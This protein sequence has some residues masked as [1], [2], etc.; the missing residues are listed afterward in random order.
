MR[1]MHVI[2]SLERGGAQAVL[3]DLVVQFQKQGC[4]QTIVYMHDGPYRERFEA[5]GIQTHQ[6]T[7]I[8]SLFD[9]IAL[10]RLMALIKKV[11]PDYLH[12]LLWA[13]NWLGR[14]AARLLRIP[15]V[16]SLH[17]NYDQ[18]G[19]VR[20]VLDR[21]MPYRVHAIIAVSHEV[22]QSFCA[23]YSNA[24]VVVIPN[25]ID[26][27]AVFAAAKI[28][29]KSRAQLD[30]MDTD[31]VIGSV[32]RFHPIKQYPLLLETFALL[33][34]NYPQARLVLV[35]QGEQERQLRD[36]AKSLGIDPYIRWV[37]GEQAYG[38]YNLFDCFVLASSKEGISIALLEAMSLGVV[39]VTFYHT[40][41]H[42]VIR[43]G[44]NGYVA[45]ACNATDFAVKIGSCCVSDQHRKSMV[46]AAQQAVCNCFAIKGMIAAYN[47]IFRMIQI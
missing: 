47:R 17:N 46:L 20:R 33:R 1:I 42:P 6:L 26:V 31:F 3:Y 8:I 18:N 10:Y 15:C 23:A 7:G 44:H 28:Q 37:I 9:P 4:E 40:A 34:E 43:D 45:K 39:P 27:D 2:T 35:G 19:A 5:V 38:Y 14:C 30:L 13:A 11:R 29:R 32:G 25:G 16:V 22:K 36:Y 24:N 12:T 21:F 41:Q